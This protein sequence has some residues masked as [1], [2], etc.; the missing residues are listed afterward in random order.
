MVSVLVVCCLLVGT[1]LGVWVFELVL[2]CLL[3]EL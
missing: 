2:L 1:C 3:F